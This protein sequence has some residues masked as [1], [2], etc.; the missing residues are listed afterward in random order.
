[1]NIYHKAQNSPNGRPRTYRPI[2]QLIGRFPIY[3]G[4]RTIIQVIR[5][6][7]YRNPRLWDFFNDM[8]I[9]FDMILWNRHICWSPSLQV[10]GSFGRS[11]LPRAVGG[12]LT[13]SLRSTLRAAQ[14]AALRSRQRGGAARGVDSGAAGD[15]E[16][17]V[18]SSDP[19]ATGLGKFHGPRAGKD[20]IFQSIPIIKN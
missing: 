7:E 11:L 6:I 2:T 3:G 14:P 19:E 12:N 9:W 20:W 16:Q 8:F 4:T 18:D 15:L 17:R 5:P 10:A 13:E 1:M